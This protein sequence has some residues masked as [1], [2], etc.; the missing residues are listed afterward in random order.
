MIIYNTLTKKKEEFIPIDILTDT[1]YMQWQDGLY[2]TGKQEGNFIKGGFDTNNIYKVVEGDVEYDVFPYY[3]ERQSDS[4]IIDIIES[5]DNGYT[6]AY[7][8]PDEHT[9]EP[10]SVQINGPGSKSVADESGN[11][12]APDAEGHEE[13]ENFLL[14]TR[15]YFIRKI[16]IKKKVFLDFAVFSQI[17]YFFYCFS[18]PSSFRQDRKKTVSR[19]LEKPRDGVEFHAV[20][21]QSAERSV[22]VVAD[23]A[24]SNVKNALPRFVLVAYAGA[25]PFRTIA[26]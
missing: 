9:Y 2:Y 6:L 22:E 26:P 21:P 3:E 20:A 7:L 19:K 15:E 5:L 14:S 16:Q 23:D 10:L 1:A 4:V 18:T 24:E 13:F 25:S 8:D 11:N 12:T 17:S